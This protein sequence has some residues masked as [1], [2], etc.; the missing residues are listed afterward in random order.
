LKLRDFAFPKNYTLKYGAL[1]AYS[2]YGQSREEERSK[3]YKT[4]VK[5]DQ[6]YP[7]SGTQVQMSN[8]IAQTISESR[9]TLPLGRLFDDNPVLV[10]V[11]STSMMKA[12]SLWAPLRIATAMQAIGLGR[13]VSTCLERVYAIQK[14]ATSGGNRASVQEQFDSLRVQKQIADP[15]SIV[16]VDDIVT[17]GKTLVGSAKR[18]AEAYPGARISAFAAM[19]T[20]TLSR[21][22]KH[23][24]DP[25]FDEITM[26]QSGKTHRNPD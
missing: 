22:F 6:F 16:L 23:L 18:L 21:N 12:A 8:H 13:E 25:V 9:R 24:H 1:F 4:A 26:Y 2:P 14:S 20:V 17:T 15:T 5:G 10:P 11:R 19:R 3:D 7:I